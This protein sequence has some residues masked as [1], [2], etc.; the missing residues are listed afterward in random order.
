MRYTSM[1][2]C[3]LAGAEAGVGAGVAAGAP[4]VDGFGASLFPPQAERRTAREQ[5]GIQTFV[6]V[7]FMSNTPYGVPIAPGSGAR[8]RVP[9][10]KYL[11]DSASGPDFHRSGHEEQRHA[12]PPGA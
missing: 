6:R 2:T 1:C 8:L 5:A 7:R 3:T 11:K 12:A 9:T 4:P 10:G